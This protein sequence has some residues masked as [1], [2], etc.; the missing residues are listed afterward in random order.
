M[1]YIC[2]YHALQDRPAVEIGAMA[3]KISRHTASLSV[4]VQNWQPGALPPELPRT[5]HIHDTARKHL[6]QE[7][8]TCLTGKQS[9]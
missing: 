5:R 3:R 1:P 8:N 2:K 4:A 7:Q 9:R 6:Q